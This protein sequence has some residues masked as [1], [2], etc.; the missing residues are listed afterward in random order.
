MS[1]FIKKITKSKKNPRNILVIGTGFER[2]EDLCESFPSIFIISTGE[3]TV[4]KR[5]LIYKESFDHL[6][7]LPD[8][9]VIVMD[10]NQDIHVSKLPPLLNRFQPI[11]LVQGIELF[12]KAEYK[13]LKNYG[14]AVTQMFNDSHLWKKIN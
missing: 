1:K 9:D 5:N 12:G 14:Y 6:E 10:R 2:L 3:Q 11:I 7:H 8:I 4:R 13:F